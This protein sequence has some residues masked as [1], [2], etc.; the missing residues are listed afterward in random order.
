MWMIAWREAVRA[1]SRNPLRSFLT[2]LGVVIGVAAVIALV[3]LGR[4][5][6]AAVQQ[7]IAAMGSNVLFISPSRGFGPGSLTVPFTVEDARFLEREAASIA[8]AA[9]AAVTNR[10]VIAGNQ[11]TTTQIVGIGEGYLTARQWPVADGREPTPGELRS[12]APVCLLGQTVATTLFGDRSP[13]G[14]RMRL[15][16]L[17]CSVIGVLAAKGQSAF[18]SD[19][20]DLVMVPL[21][22]YHRRIAGN[23]QVRFIIAAV[24]PGYTSSEA[25]AEVQQLLRERRR[26]APNES[27]NFRI[28]DSREIERTFTSTTRMLT[29]LLSAVAAISLVVG[30]IGIMNIMLVSVTERTR[31]IG[32]RLAIGARAVDV[33]TQFLVEAVVLSLAGGAIGIVLA[34]VAS[35]LAAQALG[36]PFLLDFGVIAL[37]VLFS[38]AVGV[39]FGFLPARRAARL[40][41]IVA[42]RQE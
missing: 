38:A 7:Q 35:Y 15:D 31:E 13:V 17:S 34:L 29:A 9:P 4:G 39:V 41:P 16:R 24:A 14:E 25:I 27:D 30:G 12:G 2:V 3:T 10:T 6:T 1:L 33:M 42:L 18:G 32:I 40:D 22:L 19:Q 20:D 23:T 36:F 28:T 11:S 21:R 8:I 37:A 26:V 5:A